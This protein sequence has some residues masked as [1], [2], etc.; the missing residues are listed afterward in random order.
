MGVGVQGVSRH[1]RQQLKRSRATRLTEREWL[2]GTGSYLGTF[3][4]APPCASFTLEGLAAAIGRLPPPR[5]EPDHSYRVRVPML[6]STL[7]KIRTV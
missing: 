4:N 2:A 6:F 5:R 3:S 1:R 7:P